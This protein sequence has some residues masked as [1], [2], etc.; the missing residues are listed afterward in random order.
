MKH[1]NQARPVEPVRCKRSNN[2]GRPTLI[3]IVGV[4]KIPYNIIC[5]IFSVPSLILSMQSIVSRYTDYA[6]Y[7]GVK[8]LLMHINPLIISERQ[9][10]RFPFDFIVMIIMLFFP[11]QISII[12]SFSILFG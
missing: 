12:Q 11:I 4:I 10:E 2:G 5:N 7:F 9:I 6:K 1:P 8:S 3:N